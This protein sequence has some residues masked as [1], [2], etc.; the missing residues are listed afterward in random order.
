[1]AGPGPGRAHLRLLVDCAPLAPS[2]R[3]TGAHLRHRKDCLQGSKVS[4]LEPCG[5]NDSDSDNSADLRVTG[6]V[7]AG[8]GRALGGWE[9]PLRSAGP[10]QLGAVASEL[11]GTSHRLGRRCQW[12]GVIM[13][14]RFKLQS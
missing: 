13:I 1:M 2:H 8:R 6:T 5:Y 10:S 3:D 12:P 4:E 14:R 11:L 7:A 9:L